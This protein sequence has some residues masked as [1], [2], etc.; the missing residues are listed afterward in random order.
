MGSLAKRVAAAVGL[1]TL[2][3]VVPLQAAM[4]GSGIGTTRPLSD[5][6]FDVRPTDAV[7]TTRPL[8]DRSFEVRAGAWTATK[9]P[10]RQALSDAAFDPL[11]GS[12]RPAP[13]RV[14]GPVASTTL[15]VLVW[16]A[17]AI[18]LL[19]AMTALIL[20]RRRRPMPVA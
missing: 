2:L 9:A 15:P 17:L 10:S 18:A 16:T 13:H 12:A 3:L 20:G 1:A 11:G 7:T 8:S 4:A 14:S 19:G 6:A 5:P